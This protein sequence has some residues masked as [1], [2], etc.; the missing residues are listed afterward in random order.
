MNTFKAVTLAAML[1]CIISVPA[2]GAAIS[3]SQSGGAY[4]IQGSGM[5]GVAGIDLTVTYDTSSFSSPTVTQGPLVSGALMAANT[6]L[7]GSVKVAIISSR[8]FSGSGVLA[9]LSFAKSS[10][11]TPIISSYSMIDS[12]GKTITPS[13]ATTP[14]EGT[15]LINNPG[16]PFTPQPQ[17]SPTPTITAPP[18]T[19][20]TPP[21]MVLGTVT[22]PTDQASATTS[23][24]KSTEPASQVPPA[25][26]VPSSTAATPRE[27]A[28]SEPAAVPE[29]KPSHTA[30]TSVLDRFRT[31]QGEKTPA[32][33]EAL[34]AR[35]VSSTVK[36][37]PAIAISDGIATVTLQ[38]EL[39]AA[40]SSPNFALSGAKLASIKNGESAGSWQIEVLPQKD[41]T[42]TLITILNGASSIEYPLTV[43]PPAGGLSFTEK[44]FNTFLKDSGAPKPA[45]DLNSDGRHDYLD[46][47]IYTGH[48]LLAKQARKALPPTVPET[49][50]L[51]K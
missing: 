33:M 25:P 45:F 36:Q 40:T 15:G 31:Y 37:V 47:Y 42:R 34:F 39:P 18:T 13:A 6:N 28:S 43:V 51:K 21:Q 24:P 44:G 35:D 2:Y 19:T 16:V 10:G 38:I 22:M 32:I 9:T 11:G 3:I 17:P 50:K 30:H 41:A 27:P 5:D 14:A 48:Y 46:D 8:P 1:A 49:K 4:A 20:T 7:A 12:T 23:A 29:E 26:A